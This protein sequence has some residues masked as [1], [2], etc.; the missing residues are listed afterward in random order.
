[1]AV[2][3]KDIQFE[4]HFTNHYW[5]IPITEALESEAVKLLVS[6]YSTNFDSDDTRLWLQTFLPTDLIKR[7]QIARDHE[8]RMREIK[9]DD[10]SY[11][12]YAYEYTGFA[13]QWHTGK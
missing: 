13:K 9:Y 1:M 2:S 3:K 10:A 5:G 6:S 7:Q 12:S 11:N 4:A 8:R